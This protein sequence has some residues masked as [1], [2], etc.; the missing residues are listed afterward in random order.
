M[1]KKKHTQQKLR[2]T[3]RN[4]NSNRNHIQSN[5]RLTSS[6][7]Y[8]KALEEV[9]KIRLE[10]RELYGD[11]WKENKDWEL[12]AFI[13]NKVGRLE[14]FILNKNVSKNYENEI[15]CLKDL[16]NYSLFLLENKLKENGKKSNTK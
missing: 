16:I 7:G 11:S 6:L 14:D 12:L 3:N 1:I 13:K 2:V 9:L 5:L 15:D 10:R 8:L 4:K